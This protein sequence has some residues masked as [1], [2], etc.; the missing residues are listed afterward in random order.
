MQIIDQLQPQVAV[1]DIEMPHFSGVEIA[2]HLQIKPDCKTAVILVTA[3]KDPELF[4]EALDFGVMGYVLKEN[5]ISEIQS[6]IRSVAKGD[7]YISPTLS[8]LLLNRRQEALQ[9]RGDHEGINHL[10]PSEKRILKL[11]SLDRTTKEIAEDLGISPKTVENHRTNIS[12]KVGVSGTHSLLKFAFQ[13]RS[14]L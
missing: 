4:N 8:N 5:A 3:Y 2:R 12:R 11:I 9:L 7:V 14:K 10:S 13:H 1:L 6:G